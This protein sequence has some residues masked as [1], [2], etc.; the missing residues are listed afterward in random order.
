[1][2]ALAE[3]LASLVSLFIA[4]VVTI[5]RPHRS[6]GPAGGTQLLPTSALSASPTSEAIPPMSA[7][8][9]IVLAV[10]G[11]KSAAARSGRKRALRKSALNAFSNR[12]PYADCH[13]RQ[14]TGGIPKAR[15]KA[16]LKAASDP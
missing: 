16:R 12:T 10:M 14:V 4:F 15:L 13:L 6:I 7:L 3:T 2:P 5:S 9:R 11:V 8:V 1:M